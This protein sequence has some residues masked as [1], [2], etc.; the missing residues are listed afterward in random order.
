MSEAQLT[1]LQALLTE[2]ADGVRFALSEA[3]RAQKATSQAGIIATQAVNEAEEAIHLLESVKKKVD[4]A[5]RL[6]RVTKPQ[7]P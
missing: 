7:K 5:L 3:K 2:A 6:A 1:K 4:R